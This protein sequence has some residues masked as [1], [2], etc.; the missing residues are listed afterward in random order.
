MANKIFQKAL[1]NRVSIIVQLSWWRSQRAKI[2]WT[3]LSL[4]GLSLT[5][6][7]VLWHFYD[8]PL[9]SPLSG[10]TSFQF[11]K[12]ESVKKPFLTEQKIVYAF[13]PYWNLSKTTIQPEI[14]H[15]AYFSLGI[16]ADGQI[17]TVNSDQTVEPGYAKLDS[18]KLLEL[19]NQVKKNK[20]KI[21]IVLTQFDNKSIET[22]LASPSA[23]QAT[24]DSLDSILLAYPISGIN[25]DIE[26]A[27]EATPELRRQLVTFI[28]TLRTHVN[29]KYKGVSLSIDMY[30]SAASKPLIWDVAAIAP[31]VDHIIIMAYDFHLRS[32]PTAGPVAPLFGG[33]EFWQSDINQYIKQF[34]SVTVKNK[35]LLGIPFYGYGWQTTSVDPQATTYPNTGSTFSYDNVQELLKKRTELQITMHWHEGAL[36]PYLTYIEDDKTYVVHYEDER[37]IAYKLEY[38]KQLDLGGIAIWAIGYEGN[39]RELWDAI[40]QK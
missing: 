2:K 26:Y 25:L 1:P 10:V 23:H 39:G 18:D 11:L 19:A 4:L 30:A 15:L 17:K 27:G 7:G 12:G 24:L 14:T 3:I 36:S 35:L 22:F 6:L 33:Q 32:S 21:D 5:I 13:L 40:S 34:L 20:G 28:K 31:H 9:L 16:G 37:S 29:S 38:A 8:E